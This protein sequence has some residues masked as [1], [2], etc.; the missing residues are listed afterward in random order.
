M[1]L[2][3]LLAYVHWLA[4]FTMVT[5]LASEAALCR[6]EWM[7]A[8]IVERLARVDMLYGIASVTV[9]L[10]G[11]A[12]SAWGSKGA[13]W[14]WGNPLLHSKL[15]LFVVIGLMSIRPTLTYLRWRK[16][17][18][19]GGAL[20]ADDEVRRTRK[21]VMVQAHLVPLVALL[22]VFLARGFGR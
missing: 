8:R 1:L 21:T 13:A 10:T 19:A 14:Y 16:A 2:E 17:L 11:L 5:F 22:A 18:R 15:A 12:R 9:L 6:V 20:P 3:T 4:I 7:N